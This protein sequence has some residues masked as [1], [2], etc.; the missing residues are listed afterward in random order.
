[1]SRLRSKLH[2]ED[3]PELIQTIRGSGYLLSN[4]TEK[5]VN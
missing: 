2:R 5:I 4:P 1:M 3:A